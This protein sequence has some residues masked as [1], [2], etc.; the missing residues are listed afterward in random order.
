MQPNATHN[1]KQN[2]ELQDHSL[3]LTLS[4]SSDLS[5]FRKN[6]IKIQKH[7]RHN[8]TDPIKKKLQG[9]RN[10]L[11]SGQS[12]GIVRKSLENLVEFYY[13]PF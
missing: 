3:K 11:K 10:E 2:D 12:T 9:L 4:I 8:I 1:V 13:N 6:A 7:I 5:I